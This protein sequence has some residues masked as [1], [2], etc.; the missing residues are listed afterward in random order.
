MVS[1]ALRTAALVAA[2]AVAGCSSPAATAGPNPAN[3]TAPV[4]T[5]AGEATG[6]VLAGEACSYFTAEEVGAIVGTVPVKVEERSGRGDCDYFLNAEESAKINVALVEWA[7]GGESTFESTKGF[8]E[9]TVIDLGD[10]AYSVYNESLGTLVL[11]HAG[12]S[13]I[14]V[15]AFNSGDQAA[16][17]QHAT[18]V[19]E[20]FFNK[21]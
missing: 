4:A 16:Q 20:A 11:V 18:K 2:I 15:Q 21:I 14:V 8:G 3:T 13:L 6:P 1:H 9:R 12:D 7:A 17:L 5:D 10:E 19:A